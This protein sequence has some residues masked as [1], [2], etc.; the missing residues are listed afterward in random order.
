MLHQPSSLELSL[1]NLRNN[2]AGYYAVGAERPSRRLAGRRTRPAGA[3]AQEN[4][5]AAVSQPERLI[6]RD[7]LDRLRPTVT[8][9]HE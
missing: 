5:P 1:R 2:R 7:W 9:Y 8:R 6:R 3:E 4:S